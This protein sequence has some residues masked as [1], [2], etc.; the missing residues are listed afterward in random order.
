MLTREENERL[1]RVGPGTP[2]GELL[3]RYWHPIAAVGQLLERPVRPVRLLGEEL[4]LFRD[5]AGRLGL[6]GDRCAHRLVQLK[7]GYPVPGGLR[8]PYH[9]WTYDGTGRC[10]AQPSEPPGSTFKERVRIRAY[11]VKE[12]AGLVFAYLGPQ[13][14]PLLPRWDRLVWPNVFR[15]IGFA[16]IPCNWLQCMENTPDPV[17][18]EWL[19][20][21]FFRH[22]LEQQGVPP[23]DPRWRLADG[24]CKHVVQHEYEWGPFGIDRRWV[25]EGQSEA[26]TIWTESLPL[27]F[28]NIHVTSG[29]G[30]HTFGWR[31]AIDDTHTRE[32]VVRVY[33]PG[34]EVTVPPQPVIPW[35]ELPVIDETGEFTALDTILGQDV[36]ASVAQGPITDR[37]AERLGDSDRGIIL[38]R[39]LLRSQL[40]RIEQG[41]DPINV[42]RDPAHNTC[43]E[44]PCPWDRG[45]AWGYGTDGSYVR[46]AVTSGDF[47]PP[48]L[49]EQIEDLFVAAAARRAGAAPCDSGGQAESRRQICTP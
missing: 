22:W 47:L 29:G 20:G 14:A 41:E 3:R 28:P 25:I 8:C 1:T 39:K 35:V 37:T 18:G 6:V 33:D 23:E 5:P 21:Y 13:P 30:R 10:V 12:L 2:M 44:L 24:F 42:F 9:G 49:A 36:L 17:H 32:V 15:V 45:F 38:F 40:Q 34:P 4:V 7:Y 48:V 46:G 16:E 26:R 11:P 31:V 43:I 27:V 19:H